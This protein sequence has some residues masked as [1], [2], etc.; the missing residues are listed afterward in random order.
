[1]TH[2]TVVS[3]TEWLKA[4]KDLLAKEKAFTQQRDELSRIR[5]KMPWVAVDKDY[6]FDTEDGQ[7]SL[8]ELF[9]DNGQLVVYHFM[10]GPDWEAGCKSCSFWADNF[11][12]S[13]VHLAQRDVTMLAVSRGPLHKLLAFRKRMGWQFDWVSSLGSDFNFDYGVSFTPESR[14]RGQDSYNYSKNGFPGGEAPGISIFFKDD[15]GSIYHCYSTY[16]RGLDMMNAAYHYLDLVP[17]GRD[18]D[19]FTY[20]MEWVKLR[21]EYAS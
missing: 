10:F 15:D 1:M 16:G 9:G 8:G 21:D 7:K 20:P 2:H 19:G 17:K 12:R 14:E 18:E 6:H 11:D 3:E 5:R 4:R 13:V